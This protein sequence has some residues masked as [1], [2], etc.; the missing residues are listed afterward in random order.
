MSDV[1][2]KIIRPGISRN[3]TDASVQQIGYSTRWSNFKL[4][5][6]IQGQVVLQTADTSGSVEIDCPIPYAP[7]H[8]VYCNSSAMPGKWRYGTMT[9]SVGI[10]DDPG[11]IGCESFYT[12]ATN[13]FTCKITHYITGSVRTFI[14]RIPIF[15]DDPT[16]VGTALPRVLDI[17]YKLAAAPNNAVEAIPARLSAT[18][19]YQSLSIAVSGN[20]SNVSP[21]NLA[22]YAHNL[23][24]V[25]MFIPHIRPVVAANML[26]IPLSWFDHLS[27]H[28]SEAWVD[29]NTLYLDAGCDGTSHRFDFMIF[30]QQLV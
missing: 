17:G 20:V 15:V 9:N 27:S 19:E 18:S 13:K 1:G 6:V 28:I 2:M 3:V 5:S 29:A 8:M 14:F 21:S 22:Q 11:W 7:M 16:G 25:P 12:P 24:Y 4:H 23:G 10:P 26:P 30:D